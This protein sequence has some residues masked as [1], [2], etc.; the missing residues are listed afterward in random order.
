MLPTKADVEL[1]S[2]LTGEQIQMGIDTK[3][4]A[5][6]QKVLTDL[7]SDPKLAVV[8]EYSTNA[9]DAHVE[10]GTNKPIEVTTPNAL[11]P[12][13]VVQDYGIG[14]SLD[15]IRDIY[16]QYGAS[17]KRGT[18]AQT[19]MLGLGCKSALT[20][21]NQFTIV[22]VKDGVKTNVIVSRD[23]ENVGAMTVVYHGPFDGPN[24]VEIKIP[25][26]RGDE[27]EFRN[28]AEK[29]F[30]FW[31]KGRVKLNGKDPEFV[32]GEK[33][34]DNI[35]LKR[36]THYAEK[37]RLV[38]GGV[39]YNVDNEELFG[40]QYDH[41]RIVPNINNNTRIVFFVN[42]G[43]VD[44]TPSREELHYTAHTRKKLRS[45]IEDFNEE[46]AKHIGK[47]I[48][49][50]P[51]H[52]EA[53][54][55]YK[56]WRNTVQ[57]LPSGLKYRGQEIPKMLD[58]DESYSINS[59]GTNRYN[60]KVRRGILEF[61]DRD[62]GSILVIGRDPEKELNTRQKAKLRI[63]AANKGKGYPTFYLM[64]KDKY[65][66]W[67]DGFTH[68]SWEEIQQ[69]KVPVTGIGAKTDI[70]YIITR[71][72]REEIKSADVDKSQPIIWAN[73]DSIHKDR[74]YAVWEWTEREK[75]TFLLIAKNKEKSF[76]AKFPSALFYTD[77]IRATIAGYNS[78]LTD[79]D[80]K[81]LG[82]AE[83]S[84]F[85]AIASFNDP[86]IDDKELR[87]LGE[88]AAKIRIENSDPTSKFRKLHQ[89]YRN[90]RSMLVST[91]M[92]GENLLPELE[93]HDNITAK[94]PLV[95]HIGEHYR[96]GLIDHL[97]LYINAVHEKE[98]NAV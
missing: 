19:G 16:S 42:M 23:A 26:N 15:D 18:N 58:F 33:L 79:S 11:S 1:Q 38:M 90:L 29:F 54:Q 50:Q 94:Y 89:R 63:W 20:Y 55:R 98:N 91:N 7:Y 13:F 86:R 92:L 71:Y 97:V 4:L 47:D 88:L 75:V 96:R 84:S 52:K 70:Y 34:S 8:R 61:L 53:L 9:W 12:Y 17:T 93:A 41:N 95:A 31:E 2:N 24:G 36:N 60:T 57:D 45:L 80:K 83:H 66:P 46:L 32:E 74:M 35:L 72:G 27:Q 25:V 21:T 30:S 48:N 62:E 28:K 3:S 81:M 22:A 43:D 64:E 73:L 77:W 6:L 56:A 67:L 39:S 87:Q 65:S 37:H 44:F 49:A 69:T 5:F 82:M 10:A 51:N 85:S 59:W 76:K 40:R 14:L 78:S 68:V